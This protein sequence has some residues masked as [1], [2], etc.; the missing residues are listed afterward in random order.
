MLERPAEVGTN[1]TPL[2]PPLQASLGGARSERSFRMELGLLATRAPARIK[3]GPARIKFGGAGGAGD[4][5]GLFI[6]CASRVES[7]TVRHHQ[8]SLPLRRGGPIQGEPI[9]TSSLFKPT[10]YHPN[11]SSCGSDPCWRLPVEEPVEC[12][13][14][15]VEEPNRGSTLPRHRKVKECWNGS[16]KIKACGRTVLYNDRGSTRRSFVPKGL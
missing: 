2:I 4:V 14:L 7:S 1:H 11:E 8:S 3:F 5:A 15:P 13:R 10:R 6:L 12:W 16:M 9:G